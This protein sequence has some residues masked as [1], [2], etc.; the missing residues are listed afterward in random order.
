VGV[1]AELLELVVLIGQFQ[2]VRGVLVVVEEVVQEEMLA[3]LDLLHH[4]FLMFIGQK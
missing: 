2:S 3:S 4:Y 1:A